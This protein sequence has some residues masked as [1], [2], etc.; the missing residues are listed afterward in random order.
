MSKVALGA[1]LALPSVV[2]FTKDRLVGVL[3]ERPTPPTKKIQKA[4]CSYRWCCVLTP[5][6]NI[7]ESCSQR[8]QNICYF[9]GRIC[10]RV[11]TVLHFAKKANFPSE[12]SPS[13]SELIF[14]MREGAKA[15]WLQLV[16]SIKLNPITSLN[17]ILW[18][19]CNSAP[20][21]HQTRSQNI[22]TENGLV[23]RC[24]SQSVCKGQSSMCLPGKSCF[25]SM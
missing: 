23:N 5:Q 21:S 22:Q 20:I 24:P 1:W 4:V 11:R 18:G 12:Y 13:F 14:A 16:W 10:C 2:V 7:L 6:W 8:N 25:R 17:M 9:Q 19:K 15:T 3:T